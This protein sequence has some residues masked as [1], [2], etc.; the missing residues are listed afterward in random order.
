MFRSP[1]L[2]GRQ[3]LNCCPKDAA[4]FKGIAKLKRGNRQKYSCGQVGRRLSH[5]VEV[6][7]HSHPFSFPSGAVL[8]PSPR[9]SGH[10]FNSED[11]S[12]HT[13]NI[14]MTTIMHLH[15]DFLNEGQT[16]KRSG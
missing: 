16:R 4:G 14:H 13:G 11:M 1:P 3:T 12:S 2:H 7:P 6:F 10:V 5:I 8:G 9:G 15:R